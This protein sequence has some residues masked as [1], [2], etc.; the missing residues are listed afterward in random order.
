[1]TV[2]WKNNDG[3]DGGTEQD[4]CSTGKGHCCVEPGTSSATCS[5][6]KSRQADTN[7]TP[8]ARKNVI[9]HVR[10]HGGI[11]FWTEIDSARAIALHEY[12]PVDGTPLSHG[13]IRLN[14]DMAVKIF[15]GAIAQKTVVNIINVARPMCD[16]PALQAEWASDFTDAGTDPLPK[17][18]ETRAQV[19]ET[20]RELQSAFG[21]E[22]HTP[23]E[24]AAM[25]PADIPRCKVKT[26]PRAKP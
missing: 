6:S 1:V 23:A 21:G 26:P 10:D 22:S 18:G 2:H 4:Q 24:Y 3:T 16:H 25:T 20:R 14:H 11:E 5:E 19:L 12:A 15:C 7:C 13:C 9:R 8:V 17:D